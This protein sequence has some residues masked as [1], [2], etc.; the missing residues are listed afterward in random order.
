[1]ARRKTRAITALGIICLLLCLASGGVFVCRRLGYREAAEVYEYI[2]E[3]ALPTETD[4]NKLSAVDAD[5]LLA[6][7][8]DYV[9]WLEIPGTDISYPVVQTNNNSDYL[10]TSFTRERRVGGCIFVDAVCPA[11]LSGRNTVIYGHR[12]YDGTM[13]SG[14]RWFLDSDYAADHTELRIYLEE[15][16]RMYRF[17]S[18]RQTDPWD[19][20]AQTTF[21]S[22][23]AYAEWLK[24]QL[25][26]SLYDSGSVSLNE[27][28]A[29]TLVT[30]AGDGSER[31]AVTWIP[32]DVQ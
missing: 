11:D 28:N 14:L 15:G 31:L 21:E 2:R 19:N 24:D 23:T 3:E 6:I 12:M 10:R 29:V 26:R 1:M 27:A 16:I 20:Y 17:F 18:V 7:N 25:T 9:F 22:D 5:Q 13:F 30:C 8:P 4:S 32:A